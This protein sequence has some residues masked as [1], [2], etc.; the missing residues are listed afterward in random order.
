MLTHIDLCQEAG[1]ELHV[2]FQIKR[3][4]GLKFYPKGSQVDLLD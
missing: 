3:P 1:A 4:A 2:V